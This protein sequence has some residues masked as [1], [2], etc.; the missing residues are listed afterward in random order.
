[1]RNVI[2]ANDQSGHEN[3]S[4]SE[5]SRK[6]CRM[7]PRQVLAGSSTIAHLRFAGRSSVCICTKKTITRIRELH[8]LPSSG[9][10]NLKAA[11]VLLGLAALGYLAIGVAEPTGASPRIASSA[12]GI[13]GS[14]N[15]GR[16]FDY[17]PDHYVN[18]A[19]TNEELV[20]TF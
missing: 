16:H 2:G 14:S 17:V 7:F 4:G 9:V 20:A 1:M 15:G 13:S 5:F 3:L 18:Q 6:G 11:G 10:R 19:T 12:I 8:R